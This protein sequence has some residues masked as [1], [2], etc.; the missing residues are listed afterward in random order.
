MISGTEELDKANYIFNEVKEELLSE[1]IA[2]N[3][4]IQV[5]AMIELPSA[6]SI[7]DLLAKKVD[8]FSVGT[9]DLIQYLMRLIVWTTVFHIYTNRLTQ[10]FFV[11]LKQFLS[12]PNPIKSL[13][14]YAEKG[15]DP[16]YAAL[17]LFRTIFKCIY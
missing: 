3:P 13:Y 6:V 1:K 2:F 17:L 16:I 5:G 10:P 7:I 11:H 8:F 12:N 14:A 9:N 15:R 4:D